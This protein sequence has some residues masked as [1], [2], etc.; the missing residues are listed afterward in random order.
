MVGFAN[1]DDHDVALCAAIEDAA[2]TTGTTTGDLAVLVPTNALVRD[3]EQRIRDL[4]LETIRL[5][6]YDGTPT[7]RVKIGTYQRGKGLEFKRV[8]L[9]RLE[10]DTIG[11]SQRH[12]EDDETY[13]E[14]VG[15][16][17]RQLFVAMTRARDQLWAG[18][19]GE[20]AQ[21]LQVDVIDVS[22]SGQ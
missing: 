7:D 21:M 8:F 13:R 15:L 16:L 19:V 18:W 22:G 12:N 2:G 5:G 10:P 20:P 3:Y 11:E 17:R 6:R 1:I 14:R 9:P 4:G